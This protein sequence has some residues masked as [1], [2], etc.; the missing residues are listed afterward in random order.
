MDKFAIAGIRTG[1]LNAMVKN[2]MKLTSV[3][4]PHEAVRD[5]N[6]GYWTLERKRENILAPCQGI[7]QVAVPAIKRFSARETFC[8]ETCAINRAGV[9]DRFELIDVE[10]WSVSAGVLTA[11]TLVRRATDIQIIAELCRLTELPRSFEIHL[12]HVWELL[13]AQSQG[14]EGILKTNIPNDNSQN[15]FFVRGG[16]RHSGGISDLH[17]WKVSVR[18]YHCD[19]W[20]WGAIPLNLSSMDPGARIFSYAKLGGWAG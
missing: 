4:A 15:Y 8:A 10:E 17:L 13:L 14:Q 18:R 6:A 19:T 2:L 12:A 11:H 9:A 3:R 16:N 5:F 20:S 7:E 1:Q